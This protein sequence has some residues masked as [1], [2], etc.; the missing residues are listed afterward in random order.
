M[1]VRLIWVFYRIAHSLNWIY[2]RWYTYIF[3]CI[4]LWL[5][6]NLPVVAFASFNCM[7]LKVWGRQLSFHLINMLYN[8]FRALFC[9]SDVLKMSLEC[10][11]LN[12]LEKTL[13]Y[14]Y[15]NITLINKN[16]NILA[17]THQ[18]ITVYIARAH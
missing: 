5:N 3:L 14:Y 7:F 9:T 17:F 12:S 4:T 13:P 18:T 2:I 15:F 11:Y 1:Y 16:A 8:I 10:L 6:W